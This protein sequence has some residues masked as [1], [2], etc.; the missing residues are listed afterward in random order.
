MPLE[1]DMR[2]I[3]NALDPLGLTV[4]YISKMILRVIVLFD[5]H[6]WSTFL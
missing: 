1:M 5:F 2:D 4:A 3:L 6:T